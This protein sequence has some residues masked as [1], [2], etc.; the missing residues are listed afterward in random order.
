MKMKKVYEEMKWWHKMWS[1]FFIIGVLIILGYVGSV[2]WEYPMGTLEIIGIAI[3]V[4]SVGTAIFV[5]IMALTYW[6]DH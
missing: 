5:T 6:A 1:V 3:G 2:I 4:V